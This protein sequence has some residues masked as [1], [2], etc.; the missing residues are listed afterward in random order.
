MRVPPWRKIFWM[1]HSAAGGWAI[2]V[3][4]QGFHWYDGTLTRIR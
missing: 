2:F 1:Y 3:F 4:C